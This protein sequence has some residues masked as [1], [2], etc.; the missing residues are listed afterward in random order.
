M[1]WC[2]LEPSEVYGHWTAISISVL[3]AVCFCLFWTTVLFWY[4]L[5]IS[6]Y[7][8]QIDVGQLFYL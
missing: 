4:N 7:F 6:V 3:I 2:T 5:F 1:Y 8:G